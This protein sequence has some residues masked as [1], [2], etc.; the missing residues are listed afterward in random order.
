[1]STDSEIRMKISDTM[2]EV[3]WKL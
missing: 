3:M 2:D 1:M